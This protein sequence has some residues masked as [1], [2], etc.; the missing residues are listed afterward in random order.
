MLRSGVLLGLLWALQGHHEE[1]AGSHGAPGV[2]RLHGRQ[3]RSQSERRDD[4]R[5]H[6]RGDHGQAGVQVQALHPHSCR[7]RPRLVDEQLGLGLQQREAREADAPDQGHHPDAGGSLRCKRPERQLG[8]D[9]GHSKHG[10]QPGQAAGLLYARGNGRGDA[11]SGPGF[12]HQDCQ[13][14][15]SEARRGR[16]D[17]RTKG[18]K[19][20]RLTFRLLFIH[21]NNLF[22]SRT[23]LLR[24]FGSPKPEL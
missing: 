24:G 21:K 15:L 3:D 1:L 23:C 18:R 14:A 22:Y 9:G 6:E 17:T 12:S 4:H 10:D 2:P 7:R 20:G 5:D 13:R 11:Q 8:R 16:N 19:E